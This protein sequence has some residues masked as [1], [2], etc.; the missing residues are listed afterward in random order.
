[1]K[2]IK[3][4]F[5]N[6]VEN[7]DRQRDEQISIYKN[8]EKN[9]FIK[10]I[11]K[12]EEIDPDRENE[13]NNQIFGIYRKERDFYIRDIFSERNGI[14]VAPNRQS[15][16]S[17]VKGDEVNNSELKINQEEEI[18]E[19]IQTDK[20]TDE[21]Q[22]NLTSI[23]NVKFSTLKNAVIQYKK[24]TKCIF[25]GDLTQQCSKVRKKDDKWYFWTKEMIDNIDTNETLMKNALL[26][27][28]HDKI[29]DLMREHCREE[30]NYSLQDKIEK[31]E[32]GLKSIEEM[33][34]TCGMST[35]WGLLKNKGT[36]FNRVSD[37]FRRGRKIRG[38]IDYVKY[39]HRKWDNHYK[40]VSEK[41]KKRQ[42]YF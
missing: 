2:E 5:T 30:W 42:L 6:M 29:E 33:V 40:R 9:P 4:N 11:K 23:E 1:M 3:A 38:I 13:I 25:T 16:L 10:K 19:S 18:N 24:D 34:L 14:K 15:F 8:N 7:E 41:I 22:S 32:D 28:G 17:P 27:F 36:T 35:I 12:K 39:K 20:I 21:S 31:L 26:S 37:A